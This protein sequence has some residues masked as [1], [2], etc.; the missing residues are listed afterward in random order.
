ME[1][2]CRKGKNGEGGSCSVLLASDFD[3]VNRGRY[4]GRFCWAVSVYVSS[5]HPS[6]KKAFAEKI[7]NCIHCRFF[8]MVQDEESNNFIFSLKDMN[9]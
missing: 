2:Q 7:S 3:G 1:C 8:K 9:R 6:I 5:D 4:G